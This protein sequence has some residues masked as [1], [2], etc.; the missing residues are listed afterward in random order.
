[1]EDKKEN[2]AGDIHLKSPFFK[3]LENFFYHY[4]WHTVI[5]LVLIVAILICTLQMCGKEEYDVEIIYAGPYP[6]SQNRQV[7]SDIQ[8][9]FAS[10]GE[11]R[12][13][14]GKTVVNLVH[15]WVDSSLNL[16]GTAPTDS[17]FLQQ[18]SVKNKENLKDE[19]LAGNVVIYLLSPELFLEFD[20]AERF[21]RLSDLV[22]DLPE[23]AYCR[24]EDG[25]INRFG[26]VL[27]KTP[28]G[29]L[30]GLSSLPSDT[31]LC[32]QKLSYTG[33]IFN[34]STFA[35]K[36]AYSVELLTAALSFREG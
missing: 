36:H 20:K 25:K 21:M 18:N 7:A 23:D 12:T 15:Y 9:A 34:S 32:I 8:S 22:P 10:L 19:L 27:S 4:K 16:E 11:D 33:N 17:A 31:V 35:K 26:A 13:G 29:Q 14:D 6:V 3:K 2:T 28:F 30:A 1:M 5:A 24:Y